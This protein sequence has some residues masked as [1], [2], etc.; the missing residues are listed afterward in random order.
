MGTT[1][2]NDTHTAL[3]YELTFTAKC[4]VCAVKVEQHKARLI[5]GWVTQ[6]LEQGRLGMLRSCWVPSLLHTQRSVLDP[7]F[8]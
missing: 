4:V 1:S 2:I 7:R 5:A 3:L 6:A 8:F